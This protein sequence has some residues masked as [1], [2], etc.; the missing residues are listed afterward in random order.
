MTNQQKAELYE[1]YIR[2][3]DWLNR[4]I[5]QLK[6][7]NIVNPPPKVEIEIKQHQQKIVDITHQLEKLT[8][9]YI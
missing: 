3:I 8:Q 4:K 5:S 6:A 2:K 7:E 1:D 9:G